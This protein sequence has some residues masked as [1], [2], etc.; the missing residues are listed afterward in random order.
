M[1]H[2]VSISIAQQLQD[3]AGLGALDGVE[4]PAAVVGEAATQANAVAAD[5]H[6][7]APPELPLDRRDAGRQQATVVPAQGPRR[8]FVHDDNPSG[9]EPREHPAPPAVHLRRGGGEQ[10]ADRF[11]HRQPGQDIRHPAVGDDHV[12][13]GSGGQPRG[14]ELGHH[15]ASTAACARA[16]GQGLDAAVDAVDPLDQLGAGIA[17][18]VRGVQAVDVRKQRQQVGVD[19]VRHHRRQVVVIA[20][21]VAS[22]LLNVDDVVL[23]DDGHH[24]QLQQAFQRVADVEVTLAVVQVAF[25]DQRLGH[26]NV[27]PAEQLPV[28][29]HQVALADGRQDLLER[30]VLASLAQPQRLLA[31]GDSPGGDDQHLS[32]E[33]AQP[34]H[35]VDQRGHYRRVQPV[36]A[37]GEQ[38][39]AQLGDDAAVL[40]VGRLGGCIH[41]CD[42][43]GP[44]RAPA[45]LVVDACIQQ[46]KYTTG[47]FSSDLPHCYNSLQG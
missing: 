38:V 45:G 23:I 24:A 36:A 40:Q 5:V 30:H 12:R 15:A 46:K 39:G 31:G 19:Q 29:V 33:A 9:A 32:A 43:Q 13:A 18:R 22:D 44:R 17:A 41:A 25:G 28:P 21:D 37:A 3:L 16:A 6:Q 35:L 34:S 2:L 27:M 26:L 14:L 20:E 1:H 10:R 7:V 8:A 42:R 11:A 4:L 47:R